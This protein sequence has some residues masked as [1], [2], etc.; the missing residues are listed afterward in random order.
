MW[1]NTSAGWIRR[2]VFPV[3]R[4]LHSIGAWAL[5]G[6]TLLTGLDVV[7]RYFF[8]R[9]IKGT[10]EVTE[11]VLCV[12]VFFGVGYTAAKD[13]NVSVSLVVTKLPKRVATV[14][15]SVG[16]FLSMVL[17]L[18]M[19]WRAFVQAGIYRHQ[20]LTS[21]ILHI[22]VFPL[23]YVVS[24]GCAVLFLILL[25]DFLEALGKAVTK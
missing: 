6:L 21:A 5:M 20:N 12:V 24:L 18:I 7:L 10:Y 16:C 4:G 23:L 9:P 1:L 13:A 8:V 3:T 22:P 17:A 11:V 19:T 14:V 15:V 25:A 2:L